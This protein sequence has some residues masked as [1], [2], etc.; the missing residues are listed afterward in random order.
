MYTSVRCPCT[1]MHTPV[2]AV[3][4]HVLSKQANDIIVGTLKMY[5]I[6]SASPQIVSWGVTGAVFIT[7][8][9]EAVLTAMVRK[10]RQRLDYQRL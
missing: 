4:V 10:C 1:H 5:G 6:V 9:M 8:L 3:Y 7:I 2:Y